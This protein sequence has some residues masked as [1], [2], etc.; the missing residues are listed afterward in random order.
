MS[1]LYS[2]FVKVDK[3]LEGNVSIYL[4]L[5][6]GISAILVVMEHLSSRLFV[7][8]G[9]VEN[10]NIVV[11]GLYLINI[12]GG[13]SVIIFFVLSG[14]FISRSVLKAVYNNKWSWESYL[15]NRLSRLFVVLIP[16]LILT[17]ILDSIAVEFFYY[18]GY[19]TSFENFIEFIGNLFFLQNIF[20]GVYG[21]NAPLWSLNYE[22]WYYM[23]FPLLFLLFSKQSKTSKIVYLILTLLIIST[24]GTRM[25][26]YFVIW[27]I[28]AAVLFL[29]KAFIN[30]RK[31]F[32]SISLCLLILA[33]I[34]RPLVMTGRLFTSDWTEDLFLVDLFVG[35][36]FGLFIYTL[37]YVIPDKFKVID[38]KWFGK[39]SRLIASFSFTLYLIHYPIINMVYRWGAI[40]GYKG[41]Q[42]SLISFG[43]ELVLVTLICII[44][45]YFSLF[46]EAKTSTIR[47]IIVSFIGRRGKSGNIGE[48]NVAG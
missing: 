1:K 13:P 29:P 8:Y 33:I 16:A 12:L 6:R 37:F 2:N 45:F 42:P 31:L 47:A 39:F 5:I 32:F 46:T 19:E 35:V 3:L 20:V 11:Q 44:A 26:S 18:Q 22:F 25:N 4:D 28:G 14:L 41:L 43:I 15:I 36:S 10:P 7:G 17:F 23:L 27:L 21:S 24:I 9:N 48:K 40:N 34:I 38:I 30:R